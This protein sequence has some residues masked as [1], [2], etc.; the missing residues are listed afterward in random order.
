MYR[1]HLSRIY[2]RKLPK[3]E[4]PAC[5]D[6]SKM[7]ESRPAKPGASS[8]CRASPT[9]ARS[10]RARTSATTKALAG[11]R[12]WCV[13]VGPRA[14]IRRRRWA[15]LTTPATPTACTSWTTGRRS[16]RRSRRFA[17]WEHPDASEALPAPL[18]VADVVNAY[19]D[20]T[21][22]HRRPTTA[23]EW[24]YMANAHIL[25]A[26]GKTEVAKL[27]TAR[28]RKWHED[29]AEQPARLRTRPGTKQRHREQNGD[30]DAIRARRATANRNLTVLKAALNHAWQSGR[31]TGSDEAWRRVKPFRGA[32]AARVR[33]LQIDEC[34]RLLN[35]C[36]PDFRRLVR[37]ALVTGAVMASS[38][39]PTCATS[40]PTRRPCSCARAR[41]AS[42]GGSRSTMRRQR[43]WPASPP[44]V[45]RARRCSSELMAA[46]GASRI[47]AGRCSRRARRRG[48]S[49]RSGFTSCATPGRRLRIMA[50]LPLMVAAQVL[51]HSDT[52]MV[53]KHY[54][55][56][57]QSFVRDAVRSHGAAPGAGERYHR[58]VDQAGGSIMNLKIWLTL[59]RTDLSQ[60]LSEE[61]RTAIKS[62]AAAI[63]QLALARRLPADKTAARMAKT[64]G[65]TA[66][67]IEKFRVE[68]AALWSTMIIKF[69]SS[70]PGHRQ[71]Q[72]MEEELGLN[73][74]VTPR[75]IREWRRR[76]I[77]R[78]EV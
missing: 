3:R 48:S 71:I 61:I 24:R 13:G 73:F 63:E 55:H 45:R 35:A 22:K 74:G 33:Y 58:D 53:E 14:A 67:E 50:G 20:W 78:R 43:S 29:L 21:A 57:A 15:R 16:R 51:G 28:L 41:A 36:E 60:P 1:G 77:K 8:P 56:L 25:P 18:A 19:L 7:P 47:S 65:L 52:R 37:G 62:T 69:N 75:T 12:G 64:V 9:G 32:D 39:A 26:L 17:R 2:S 4:F 11:A 31:I 54:G 72:L 46:D 23:R 44:A 10:S 49:P 34:T 70:H 59:A 42:R 38:A 68:Q 40:T 6:T 66:G 27:T 30:A 5:H 76:V